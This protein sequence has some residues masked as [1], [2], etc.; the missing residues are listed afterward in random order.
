V[1]VIVSC[2]AVELTATAE[3]AVGEKRRAVSNPSARPF[4]LDGTRLHDIA[5]DGREASALTSLGVL[6]SSRS[7]LISVSHGIPLD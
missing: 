7:A 4:A 6:A 5:N 2:D 1:K 3:V